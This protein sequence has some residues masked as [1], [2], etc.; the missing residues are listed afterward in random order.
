MSWGLKIAG[1]PS[2]VLAEVNKPENGIP[3]FVKDG[4]KAV[5]DGIKPADYSNGIFV[6]TYGHVGD[7]CSSNMKLVCEPIRIAEAAEAVAA[8]TP[9]VAAEAVNEVVPKVESSAA[10]E[11]PTGNAA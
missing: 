4:V 5:A 2:F 1:K 7:G 3:Q 6:E 11:A 8:E 9:V 10:A